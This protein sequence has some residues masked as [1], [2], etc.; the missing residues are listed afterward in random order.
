MMTEAE[1]MEVVREMIPQ[2]IDELYLLTYAPDRAALFA[3]EMGY[4]LHSPF[5]G[6]SSV[7]VGSLPLSNPASRRARWSSARS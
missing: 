1:L 7:G 2:A 5:C 3:P 4:P 6:A